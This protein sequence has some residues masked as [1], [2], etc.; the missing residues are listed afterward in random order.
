[1]L[2]RGGN[3]IPGAGKTLEWLASED[4]RYVFLTNGGGNHEHMKAES[5]RKKLDVAEETIGTRVI[6]SHTPMQGWPAHIKKNDTILITGQHP[7]WAREVAHR[8]AT[9]FIF[10]L[11]KNF[12]AI[13]QVVHSS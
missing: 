7:H 9:S 6:Q 8:Y 4:I 5:L 11:Q 12:F 3:K 1:M 2:Y 10:R 13:T